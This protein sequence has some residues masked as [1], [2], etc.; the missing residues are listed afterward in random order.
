MYVPSDL[1]TDKD[2]IRVSPKD[3]GGLQS[4]YARYA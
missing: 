3:N 2:V 4:A 1:I